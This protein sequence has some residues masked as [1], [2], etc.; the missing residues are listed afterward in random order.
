M[1]YYNNIW[2]VPAPIRFTTWFGQAWLRANLT[3]PFYASLPIST[4]TLSLRLALDAGGWDPGVIPEDWHMYLRCFFA[5]DER[6]GLT[7]VFLPTNGDAPEG[8]TW[9]AGMITAFQQSVRHAWGAEDVGYVVHKMSERRFTWRAALRFGQVYSDHVLRA[10]GWFL[11][12]GAYLLGLGAHP[13]YEGLLRGVLLDLGPHAAV[14]GPLFG[15]GAVVMIATL[16]FEMSRQPLPAE[17]SRL[18]LVAENVLMWMLLPLHGLYLGMLPAM[19]AQT[20]LVLGLPL[21]YKVTP[22]RFEVPGAAPQ[23]GACVA[24]AESAQEPGI[25]PLHP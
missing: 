16:V 25:T 13:G 19:Q 24:C 1:Q 2:R 8:D 22:K 21:S 4:Y 20:M 5:R 23:L 10:A 3:M 6:V 18:R 12:M 17:V 15:I 11:I 7:P 14:L 9:L